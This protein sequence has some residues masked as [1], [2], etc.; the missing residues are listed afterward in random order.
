M[1]YKTYSIIFSVCVLINPLLAV[2]EELDSLRSFY[3]SNRSGS[4]VRRVSFTTTTIARTH[5]HARAHAH[6]HTHTHTHT[7]THTFENTQSMT[8]EGVIN[9]SL[10]NSAKLCLSKMSLTLFQTI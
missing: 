5:T 8:F 6:A 2:A 3:P 10:I 9:Q 1:I 7:R 4:V